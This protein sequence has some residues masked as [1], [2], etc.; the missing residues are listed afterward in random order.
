[1]PVGSAEGRD[2][3][4]PVPFDH[5]PLT[6]QDKE[7][8]DVTRSLGGCLGERAQKGPVAFEQTGHEAQECTLNFTFQPGPTTAHSLIVSEQELQGGFLLRSS[9]CCGPGQD[10]LSGLAPAS[11]Q[12]PQMLSRNQ[13]EKQLQ[14]SPM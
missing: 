10:S 9:V 5:L 3:R 12:L 14:A 8:I 7:V 2:K 13:L 1:M 11:V 6:L 4:F